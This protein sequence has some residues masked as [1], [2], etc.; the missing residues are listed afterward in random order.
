MEN[1]WLTMGVYYYK[2]CWLVV[3]ANPSKKD[4]LKASWD[5][6]IPNIWK[7]K[8]CSKPPTRKRTESILKFFFGKCPLQNC[9]PVRPCQWPCSSTKPLPTALNRSVRHLTNAARRCKNRFVKLVLK[10]FRLKFYRF[11]CLA[12]QWHC[13]TLIVMYLLCFFSVTHKL[14]H[15]ANSTCY[16]R[17]CCKISIPWVPFSFFSVSYVIIE[18]IYIYIKMLY[19]VRCICTY[20]VI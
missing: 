14:W 6:D 7:N 15:K 4:G 3:A 12:Y 8:K 18:C 2:Y 17:S 20:I 9:C 13:L 16:P 11:I 5:D 19:Y 1:H 10:W